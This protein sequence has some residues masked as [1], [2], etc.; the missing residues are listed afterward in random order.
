M[1][2]RVLN[3]ADVKSTVEI[4]K[5]KIMDDSLLRNIDRLDRVVG[6][7]RAIVS[8]RLTLQPENDT[9]SF[10]TADMLLIKSNNRD[11]GRLSIT[12]ITAED[13]DNLLACYNGESIGRLDIRDTN[14]GFKIGTLKTFV[15]NLAV[16]I[17]GV[18]ISIADSCTSEPLL[19]GSL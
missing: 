8:L 17:P 19:S 16:S 12:I 18:E 1:E 5:T 7:D 6:N 9:R 3:K 11:I 4:V 13:V 15:D 10:G 2:A 14:E